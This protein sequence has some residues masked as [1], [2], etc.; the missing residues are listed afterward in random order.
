MEFLQ[1]LAWAFLIG[2]PISIMLGIAIRFLDKGWQPRTRF[3]VVMSRVCD[4]VAPT[5]FL[6]VLILALVS[7][8]YLA[9][10]P[11]K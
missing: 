8:V 2:V 11:I 1:K 3:E 7:A 9:N 6:F 10:P 5:L 4:A